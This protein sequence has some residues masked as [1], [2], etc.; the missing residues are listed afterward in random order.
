MSRVG[1][2]A[3]E[4]ARVGSYR[5]LDAG[6]RVIEVARI[7]GT[8]DKC[9]ELDGRFRLLGRRRDRR[10]RFRRRQLEQAD[11]AFVDLPPISVYQLSGRYFVIDGNRRVAEAKRQKLEYMDA[12]VTEVIPLSDSA[13][14]DSLLA[15][16]SVRGL[17]EG[18]VDV[19]CSQRCPR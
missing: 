12:Q 18:F 15:F 9:G 19:F 14:E 17:E 16:Q 5:T 3:E 6:P 7:T 1:C 10:E 8:V 11:L 13:A 2:F 4:V